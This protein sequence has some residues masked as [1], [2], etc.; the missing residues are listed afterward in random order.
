MENPRV[1]ATTLAS[2]RPGDVAGAARLILARVEEARTAGARLLVLPELCLP[3]LTCGDLLAQPL[4]LGA[5]REAAEAIAEAS[6][7][8]TLVFGLPAAVGAN[9]Y[10]AALVA[11]GGRILGLVLKN[12]LSWRERRVFTPGAEAMELDGWSC[13]VFAGQEAYFTLPGGQ[14]FQVAFADDM[15]APGAA[16]VLA[17][18]GADPARA[19][20]AAARKA[21]LLFLAGQRLCTWANA[22]AAESTTD[23]VYDGQ[24]L[25]AADGKVIAETKAFSGK[26]A[27]SG[28]PAVAAQAAWEPDPAMPYAPMDGAARAAWCREALEIAAQGLATRMARIGARGASLGLSGGLD[29]AMALLITLRAF[30]INQ[31]D[32]QK[33]YAVSLPAFGTSKKTRGN[34]QALLAACGLPAREIDITASVAQHFRDI[35]HPE[36][37]HDAV[38]ENAQ[39]R[40]RTQVL[41]DIANQ[42]GGLMIGPGDMSEL[43]LGFTT[44]GG[45]HMSMYGVNA[46]LYKTAIRL[47]IVQYAADTDNTAISLALRAI[48]DTPISP[49]LIPGEGGNI[50]QKTEDIL[51]PYVLNDFFLYH[52]LSNGPGPAELLEQALKAFGGD[53]ARLE[54]LKRMRGFFGRFFASQFKRSCLPDGPQVL[55]LSLSPRGGLDM[56]SD[57]TSSLWTSAVDAL[58]NLEEGE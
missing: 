15:A 39:A 11:G 29:S 31:L 3:G 50:Q 49:E 20:G 27:L 23:Q 2:G 47:I 25:I 12:K 28:G 38:F 54:I 42:I 48:L 21:R 8:M 43:A 13:P 22:G 9:V 46:G 1:M 36:G 10:N 5:C 57:A 14:R 52:F 30:E 55:G 6:G 18:L 45:D 17:L 7:D 16:P 56:P 33:L 37:R 24:A 34:A 41:M 19:G 26:A 44:Y 53:Y 40:E 35:G 58:I 51:G 4:L 32:A